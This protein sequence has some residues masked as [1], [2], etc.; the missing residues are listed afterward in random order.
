[1]LLSLYGEGSRGSWERREERSLGGWWGQGSSQ[2]GRQA[3]Y[4]L[5]APAP[6]FI[7]TPRCHSRHWHHHR[8]LGPGVFRENRE[9]PARPPRLLPGV[10]ERLKED[11]QR[12]LSYLLWLNWTGPCVISGPL[13]D[14]ECESGGCVPTQEVFLEEGILGKMCRMSLRTGGHPGHEGCPRAVYGSTLR[15]SGMLVCGG[16]R[17]HG[18]RARSLGIRLRGQAG[19]RPQAATSAVPRCPSSPWFTPASPL[20]YSC[21]TKL[22]TSGSPS[23]PCTHTPATWGPVHPISVPVTP[24]H[25]A[26]GG[27]SRPC[28]LVTGERRKEAPPVPEIRAPRGGAELQLHTH[29]LGHAHSSKGLKG[30]TSCARGG[31]RTSASRPDSQAAATRDAPH[32]PAAELRTSSILPP[33]PTRGCLVSRWEVGSKGEAACPTPG[34]PRPPAPLWIA[35]GAA[36]GPPEG[37]D[38]WSLS[39][40][41]RGSGHSSTP[42]VNVPES[43][44][45]PCVSDS[46]HEPTA[47]DQGVGES[48]VQPRPT[49]GWQTA[50]T[51]R[52]APPAGASQAP[53]APTPPPTGTIQ[54]EVLDAVPTRGLTVADRPSFWTP[55]IRP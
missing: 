45:A 24:R 44:C 25:P 20:F 18:G 28:P 42:A 17:G 1:M 5:S 22:F 9:G 11:G 27:H 36:P 21:K 50:E 53:D 51:G 52:E 14:V 2:P 39:G 40:S 6:G 26:S 48:P 8:G 38:T 4:F 35:G 54:V 23:A 32:A 49:G 29:G 12:D 47:G 15:Q 43:V 13:G 10:R 46:H 55:A 30:C 7:D 33:D 16:H 37:G 31:L 19:L 41:S 34:T 3:A